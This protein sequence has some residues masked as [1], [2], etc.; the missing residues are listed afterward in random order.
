MLTS[1]DINSKT[2]NLAGAGVL[3]FG[4]AFEDGVAGGF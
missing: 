1:A 3:R 4:V 2:Y